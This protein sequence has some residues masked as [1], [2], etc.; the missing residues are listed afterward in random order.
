V[1]PDQKSVYPHF[2]GYALAHQ[3]QALIDMSTGSGG[4]T[5]LSRA[6]LS[7]LEIPLPPLDEQKRIVAT[8]DELHR[9]VGIAQ[10]RVNEE[11]EH[12]EAVF[13]AIRERAIQEH[14]GQEIV[15]LNQVATID[16]GHAFK[17]S[18]Y[19]SQGHYLIRIGN[20]KDGQLHRNDDTFVDLS[21]DPKLLK[22]S[23]EEGDLLLTLTGNIGRIAQVDGSILPAALNQR[24]A[25]I[26]PR[27]DLISAPFL[28]F[29]LQTSEFQK[30]VATKGHGTAQQNVSTKDVE[31]FQFHLPPLQL[32]EEISSRLEVA[33]HLSSS[34]QDIVSE[35]FD[36]L[37]RVPDARLRQVLSEGIPA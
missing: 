12:V 30:H 36:L 10:K 2:L 29:L 33:A 19:T 7:S 25:R 28:R 22:F 14:F 26:R 27:G 16:G 6:A 4:Q 31:T 32:Q 35:K 8:L 5:E 11:K 13:G 18:S 17:S 3:E 24:V 34:L 1:R 37:D 9:A 15:S 21:L 23:L 20:V